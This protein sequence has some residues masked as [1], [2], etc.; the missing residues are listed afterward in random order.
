MPVVLSQK[1]IPTLLTELYEQGIQS[2]LVEG[3]SKT[4][5]GFIDEGLWD[6]ARIETAPLRLGSGVK[7]PKIEGKKAQK[8]LIEGNT[9]ALIYKNS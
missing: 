1:D 3:G 2:L 8:L 9:I 7:A 6:E 5:Q 4:L